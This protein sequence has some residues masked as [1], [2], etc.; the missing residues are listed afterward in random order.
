MRNVPHICCDSPVKVEVLDD[1]KEG[2]AIP[3]FEPLVRE[4]GTLDL[5]AND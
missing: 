1:L 2:M 5:K 4:K 3:R